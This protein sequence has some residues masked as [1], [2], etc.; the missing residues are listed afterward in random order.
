MFCYLLASAVPDKKSLLIRIMIFC[1]F[2]AAFNMFLFLSLVFN[3]LIIMYWGVDFFGFISF[4][5]CST[6]WICRFIC[7]TEFGRKFSVIIFSIFFPALYKVFCLSGGAMH[8]CKIFLHRFFEVQF[9][10]LHLFLFV[11]RLVS[12]YWFLQVHWL[13]SH[14][15]SLLS[16]VLKNVLCSWGP[17]WCMCSSGV[18]KDLWRALWSHFAKPF[19]LHG[20]PSTF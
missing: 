11:F 4:G 3:S 1:L 6:Y 14:L 12:F 19:A 15:H 18:A 17:D 8:H 16:W 13:F 9:V 20:L 10:I 7:F 5:I 2:L